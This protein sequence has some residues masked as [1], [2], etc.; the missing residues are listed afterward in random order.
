[1]NRPDFD[2]F[3]ELWQSGPD[4]MEREQM[5]A[6]ARAARRKGRLLGLLDYAAAF[7]IVVMSV[8]GLFITHTPLT[9]GVSAIIV[10]A[11]IW[12]TWKR[13]QMRQMMRTLNTSDPQAFTK[14]SIRI[15]RANLRRVMFSL[16]ALPFLVPLALAWKVGV[17]TGGGPQEV[18]DALIAWSQTIRAP[19]MTVVLLIVAGLSLRSRRKLKREIEQLEKLRR[20]YELESDQ[21]GAEERGG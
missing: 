7:L 3:A 15:A 1:M 21:D 12:M 5:Q 18:L 16:S 4:P 20:G 8:G 2:E 9:L 11:I 19:I 13:R 14:S 17:R 6:Y 10:V